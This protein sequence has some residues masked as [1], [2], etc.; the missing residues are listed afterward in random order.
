MTQTNPPR[1]P[2]PLI[3]AGPILRKTTAS[4]INLWL[5]SSKPVEGTFQVFDESGEK[6][7]YQAPLSLSQQQQVGEHAFVALWHFAG[8][9]PTNCALFYQ[10]DT[11]AGAITELIPHLCYEEMKQK[12]LHFLCEQ[13]R[14]TSCMA[15]AVTHTIVALMRWLRRIKSRL[16]FAS[17]APDLL[18]LSG[19]QIYADHVADRR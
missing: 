7:L 12:G 16:A 17:R 14:I 6:L 8:E 18:L 13:P 2:L 15:P 5:V 9:Y 10:I 3:L 11:Q 4:E 1:S 19:D